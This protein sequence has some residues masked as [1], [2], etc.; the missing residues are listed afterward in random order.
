MGMKEVADDY[1]YVKRAYGA[2]TA[3]RGG[4]HWDGLDV[5]LKGQ[6][7]GAI[8]DLARVLKKE[9]RKE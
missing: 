1:Y 4:A 8:N 7:Q 5:W 6:I 9:V 2:L 3:V